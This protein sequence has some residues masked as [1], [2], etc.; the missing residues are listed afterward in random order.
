MSLNS[1]Y[2]RG[3][4]LYTAVIGKS[5][6]KQSMAAECDINNIMAKYQK[7]GAIAHINKHGMEYGFASGLDFAESMRVVKDG[8]RMFD[9][10]P[11]LLRRRFKDDPAEFLDFVQNPDNSDEMLK[12]GLIDKPV[13]APV[14][15]VEESVVDPTI[16]VQVDDDEG[17]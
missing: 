11:S 7:T 4:R 16:V 2:V 15:P 5:R 1:K 6:T 13:E 14:A 17:E 8:Q 9:D 10:L 3:D 12:L